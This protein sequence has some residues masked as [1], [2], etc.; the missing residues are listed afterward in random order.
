MAIHG[1]H[2]QVYFQL[3]KEGAAPIEVLYVRCFK[4][5]HANTFKWIFF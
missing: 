2:V 4:A 5:R 1:G 3:S